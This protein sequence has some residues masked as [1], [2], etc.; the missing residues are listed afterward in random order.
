MCEIMENIKEHGKIEGTVDAIKALLSK[1][2]TLEEAFYL[3]DVSLNEREMYIKKL[4][5]SF[6]FFNFM[7]ESLY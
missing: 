6:V 7:F 4:A 2:I 1:N 3:L 5:M